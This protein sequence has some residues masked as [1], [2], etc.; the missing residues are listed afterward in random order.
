[1]LLAALEI[2]LVKSAAGADLR[3]QLCGCGEALRM[4]GRWKPGR[5]ISIVLQR[6]RSGRYQHWR[7][8]VDRVKAGILSR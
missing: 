3:E 7:G 2:P 4:K 6:G 1:M 8:E 5:Y